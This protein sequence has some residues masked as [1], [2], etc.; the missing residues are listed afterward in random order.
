M[1][2]DYNSILYKLTLACHLIKFNIFVDLDGFRQVNVCIHVYCEI[3]FI[4]WTIN[5]VFF[6]GSAIHKFKIPVELL[7]IPVNLRII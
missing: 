7:F 2:S 1:Y 5:F 4:C 3:I 6:V